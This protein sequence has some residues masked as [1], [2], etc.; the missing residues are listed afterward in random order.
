[1]FH[2]CSGLSKSQDENYVDTKIELPAVYDG[3]DG[4]IWNPAKQRFTPN[5]NH[6]HIIADKFQLFNFFQKNS[7]FFWK[8]G[9]SPLFH[10]ERFG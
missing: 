4:M 8:T 2:N 10:I 9:D 7:F 3:M 5:P 1:L 6:Q